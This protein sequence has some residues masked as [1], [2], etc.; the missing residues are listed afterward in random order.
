VNFAVLIQ[1]KK[2]RNII[3]KNVRFKYV[4]FHAFMNIIKNYMTNLE[5]KFK[6]IKQMYQKNDKKLFTIYINS[7]FRFFH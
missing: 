6:K 1:I 5:E 3:V 7:I 4:P 2:K